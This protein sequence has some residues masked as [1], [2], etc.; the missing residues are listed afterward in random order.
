MSAR[1][2]KAEK[3][4]FPGKDTGS[5]FP[6]ILRNGSASHG[7]AAGSTHTLNAPGGVKLLLAHELSDEARSQIVAWGINNGL[8]ERTPGYLISYW[9]DE[10]E[11]MMSL[12]EFTHEQAVIEAD[13]HAEI[14]ETEVPQRTKCASG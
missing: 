14:T 11:D 6:C 3:R 13:G 2:I 8:V 4:P 12:F 9:D 5:L 1:W 10:L 7:S